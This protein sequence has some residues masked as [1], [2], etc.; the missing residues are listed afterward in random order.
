[1]HC[2]DCPYT[3][4]CSAVSESTMHFWGLLVCDCSPE[5][6]IFSSFFLPHYVR[7]CWEGWTGDEM[8]SPTHMALSFSFTSCEDYPVPSGALTASDKPWCWQKQRD[9]QTAVPAALELGKDPN[10]QSS[11]FC[12]NS[13]STGLFW[14]LCVREALLC[15]LFNCRCLEIRGKTCPFPCFMFASSCLNMSRGL[16]ITALTLIKSSF[17]AFSF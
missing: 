2:S 6:R 9:L 13:T 15:Y 11:L 1:M 5:K 10:S 12:N 17:F 14:G 16:Q 7:L 3:I 8:L 4:A